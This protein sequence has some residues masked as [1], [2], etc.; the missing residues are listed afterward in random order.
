MDGTYSPSIW[1]TVAAAVIIRARRDEVVAFTL[2]LV[3][4][5]L[6]IVPIVIIAGSIIAGRIISRI[7]VIRSVVAFFALAPQIR[8]ALLAIVV[9]VMV[10]HAPC[11]IVVQP[12][13]ARGLPARSSLKR[14]RGIFGGGVVVLTQPRGGGERLPAL[15]THVALGVALETEEI[16]EGRR[17]TGV[18]HVAKV[19]LEQRVPHHLRRAHLVQEGRHGAERENVAQRQLGEDDRPHLARQHHVRRVREEG[20]PLTRAREQLHEEMRFNEH[21]HRLQ[22][23]VRG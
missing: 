8:S 5:T 22:S 10:A 17:R 2:I 20:R 13:P 11:T 21:F 23:H 19:P 1:L 18:A 6:L 14:K 12:M 9:Y 7:S 3:A 16:T 4:S 15:S